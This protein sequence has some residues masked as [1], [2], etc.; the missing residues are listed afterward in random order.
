MK[1]LILTFLLLLITPLTAFAISLNEL[2]NN[3]DR[4]V[5]I[6]EAQNATVYIDINSI[7]SLRY[8]PPYYTLQ[9]KE[10]FV[11]Y[12][13]NS[14]GEMTNIYNYDYNQS[15]ASLMEKIMKT[16]PLCSDEEFVKLVLDEAYKNSGITYGKT[17]IDY[18]D[19]NGIYI[20]SENKSSTTKVDFLSNGYKMANFV[21][22][23]YYTT[24]FW[25]TK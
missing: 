9:T 3:P 18:Y 16:N 6:T 21:F 22:E 11:A 19:L 23:K 10:Y 4:Y 25:I 14:I 15:S 24:E 2:Q 17:N 1:K 20:T 5:S 8:A 12:D 7:K 13:L